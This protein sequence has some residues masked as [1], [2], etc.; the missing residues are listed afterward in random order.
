[1][2]VR[3]VFVDDE[4]CFGKRRLVLKFEVECVSG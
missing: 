2:L 3:V 1:M 4:R